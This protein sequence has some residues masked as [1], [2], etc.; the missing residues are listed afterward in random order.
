MGLENL[1]TV[2]SFAAVML[3]LSLQ[4]TILVQAVIAVSGLRGWNLEKSLTELL[5]QINPELKLEDYAT[6]LSQAVLEHPALTHIRGLWGKGRQRKA[7][8]IRPEEL[9]RV[10]T[11]LATNSSSKLDSATQKVVA[12][13]LQK[14]VPGETPEL[15]AKAGDLV[16]E[17]TRLLP[18][19]PL[20]VEAAVDRAFKKEQQ[21]EVEIRTWFNTIMDRSTERF[22]IYS[23][24]ITAAIAFLL[25]LLLHIDSIQVFKQLSTKS[26]VRTSIVQ[27]V[28][29]TLDR[30]GSMLTAVKEPKPLAS[31]AIRAMK[32]DLK[33]PADL[34][35]L[36]MVP[37]NLATRRAG[38][39]WLTKQPQL[40]GSKLTK[41][42]EA[43][44]DR[45]KKATDAHL[46]Q[47]GVS[48][49]EV[50]SRLDQTGLQIIP[51]PIPSWNTYCQG[52]HLLGVIMT[53]LFLSLGAPFWFNALSQL[54]NLRPV[55]AEK[56][57]KQ[58]AREENSTAVP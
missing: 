7:T 18:G 10:L 2:M 55:L 31:E 28:D 15:A 48:F 16:S 5:K 1:D 32:E 19:Y 43:Y 21:I 54:A 51:K 53:G 22:I 27:Q 36:G 20:A 57:Q 41:A 52:L 8:A 39:E 3:L 14:T 56:I 17:L 11:D 26:D 40:T 6:K 35:V 50:R 12:D 37:D 13:A 25:V 58:T 30:A 9:L 33:D 45:F 38:E 24:W 44:D 47:L 46:K 34:Q 4:V 23:R 42:L 49:D 29:A